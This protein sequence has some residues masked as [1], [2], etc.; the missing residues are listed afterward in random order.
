M[1]KEEGEKYG[2]KERKKL[3]VSVYVRE[4]REKEFLIK[5]RPDTR[6]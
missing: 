5:T 4:G 1:K 6:P 3:F 2:Q